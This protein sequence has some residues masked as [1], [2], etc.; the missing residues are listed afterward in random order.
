MKRI[1]GFLA[2]SVASIV[3]SI[4]DILIYLAN[5]NA[6]EPGITGTAELMLSVVWLFASILVVINVVVLIIG[7]AQYLRVKTA[8]R[9]ILLWAAASLITYSLFYVIIWLFPP[10]FRGV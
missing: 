3:L 2:I 4:V 7:L 10:A 9:G 8:H 5:R 6:G 1:N